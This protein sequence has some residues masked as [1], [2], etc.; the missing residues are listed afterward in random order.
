MSDMN[1]EAFNFS[2]IAGDNPFGEQSKGG[3][4]DRFY[5]LSKDENKRGAAVIRFLP[6]PE[7]KLIQQLFR[8]NANTQQ[9]G[10][11]RW[12]SEWSPQNIN[13]ADP[14]HDEWAKLWR[15]GRKEEARQFSRATRYVTNILVVKDPSAPENEGKVFLLDMSTSLKEIVADAMMPSKADIALGKEPVELFNPLKGNNFRLVSKLGSNNFITYEASGAD[16]KESS[17]FESKEEAVEFIKK[18]CYKL[19]DFLKPEAYRSYE[20]L[21]QELKRVKFEDDVQ[22][23]QPTNEVTDPEADM[24]T[25]AKKDEDVAAPT[26]TSEKPASTEKSEKSKDENID[27]FLDSLMS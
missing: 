6:D 12:F 1:F 18:N 11:R 13:G 25:W 23:V 4:D 10:E 24:P 2:S 5:K 17:V 22:P 14:F 20:D 27:D 26:T 9:N 16:D 7:M 21:Q 15:A 19:S 3:G 8:I